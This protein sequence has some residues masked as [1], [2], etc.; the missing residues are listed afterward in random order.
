MAFSRAG[1]I[2]KDNFFEL[3]PQH[4]YIEPFNKVKDQKLMWAVWL[5]TDPDPENKMYRLSHDIKLDSVK[6]Y[7]PKF[8]LEDSFI[9]ELIDA[10]NLHYLSPAA[11]AFKE[12]EE[13]LIHR[14]NMIRRVQDELS[15]ISMDNPMVLAEKETQALLSRIDKMRADTLKV[16]KQYDEVKKLFE[17]EVKNPKVFGGRKETLREKGDL[18][19]VKED[20][21]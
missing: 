2:D 8:D 15:R 17:I 11:R 5:W 21:E 16:Y 14:S 4:K 13:S 18:V 6:R 20:Y 19:I 12:E 1:H 9:L 3:N 7:Y 10:Y